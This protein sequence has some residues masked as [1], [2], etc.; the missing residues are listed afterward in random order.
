MS[1]PLLDIIIHGLDH[2]VHK[3]VHYLPLYHKHF[4]KYRKLA[5][6]T[7]KIIIVEIGVQNGGSLDLW[8]EYFG[9][10]NCDIYGVDIDPRCSALERDNIK[11]FI[12]DQA[13]KNFLNYLK[14]TIPPPDIFIDDGGHTMTQQIS[15]FDIMFDHVK[16]GGIF[17]C[18]DTHTSYWPEYGGGYKLASS[19]MEYSKNLVDNINGYHHGRV[20]NITL[21][22]SGIHFYDSMVF[23]DKSD[24]S[25]DKPQAVVWPSSR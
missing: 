10:D 24:G 21:H 4:E 25:I 11:I 20:D 23:F 9:K 7:N 14:H 13:D 3:W 22:C 16:P 19:F 2:T 8:N 1:D 18:E 5:S 17:L 15:T 12:G 6:P